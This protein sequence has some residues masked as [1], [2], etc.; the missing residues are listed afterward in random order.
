MYIIFSYTLVKTTMDEKLLYYINR[1]I[2]LQ[3]TKLQTQL[4]QSLTKL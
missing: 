4:M 3:D 2:S 1:K